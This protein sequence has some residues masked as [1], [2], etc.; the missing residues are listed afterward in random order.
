MRW[1]LRS[2]RKEIFILI[3]GL[4]Y[5]ALAAIILINESSP[6]LK[7]ICQGIVPHEIKEADAL[8]NSGTEL[9]VP[10]LTQSQAYELKLDPK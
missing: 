5:G 8:E 10:R 4:V 6:S 3:V 1:Y 2:K 9:G 7:V